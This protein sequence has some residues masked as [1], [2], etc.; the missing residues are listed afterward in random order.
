MLFNFFYS[1]VLVVTRAIKL[2]IGHA[3]IHLT[4]SAHKHSYTIHKYLV[5]CLRR[6]YVKYLVLSPKHF[7]INY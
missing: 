3:S 6:L 4:T 1:V 2:T 7:V 5:I